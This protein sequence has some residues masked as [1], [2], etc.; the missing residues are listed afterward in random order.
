MPA[1]INDLPELIDRLKAAE[2]GFIF[3][4][5]KVVVADDQVQPAAELFQ[6]FRFV[7]L[8]MIENIA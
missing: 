6:K 4:N 5:F 2:C 7:T 3:E 1:V 8:V